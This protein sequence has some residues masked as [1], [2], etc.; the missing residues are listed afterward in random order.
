MD[1]AFYTDVTDSYRLGRAGRIRTGLGGVYFDMLLSLVFMAA[2][3]VTG[4]EMLLVLVVMLNI[5]TAYQFIP[6]I[7]L[8]GYWVLADLTGVPD[9]F[10]MMGAFVRSVVPIPAWK[11]TKLPPLKPWVRL[12]FAAYTLI[13]FPA[14]IFFMVYLLR[15]VPT[16]FNLVWDASLVQVDG[17]Q[18]SWTNGEWINV[19]AYGSQLF[20]LAVTMIGLAYFLYMLARTAA[21]LLLR[22]ART[23]MLRWR[24]AALP[25]R[26]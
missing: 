5:N 25:G 18:A 8:D 6:I 12:V 26:A 1:P 14:M 24:P 22:L 23:L 7:R 19:A 11:G 17:I 3:F 20:L 21:T 10:S 15:K 16:I 4:A 9:F 13:A 2:Y